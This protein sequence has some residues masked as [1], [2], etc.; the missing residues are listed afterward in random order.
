MVTGSDERYGER[1]GRVERATELPMLVLALAYVPV[2]VVGYLRDVPADVSGAAR[3][4]GALIVAAFVAELLVKLAVAKERLAYLKENWLDVLIVAVPFL[5]PLRI[6]RVLRVLPFVARGAQG[7]GTILGRYS[8]MYVVFVGV[9]AVLMSAFLVLVFERGA[10][11][12]IQTFGEAL[13]WAAQT[14]TTLGYGD[15][16]PIT[17][18]GRVV[19]TLLMVLGITLFGVLTAGVA[20]YFVHDPQKGGTQGDDTGKILARFDALEARLG[21]IEA[22]L[23]ERS[24][25]GDAK[26]NKG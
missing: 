5:R 6:L 22:K 16:V 4:V 10:G 9:V 20:A 1:L 12:T 13:W 21:S 19:A 17:T 3:V 25:E 26:D 15:V 14:V 7:V 2:F 18:G 8:G 11:G 24:N 23:E